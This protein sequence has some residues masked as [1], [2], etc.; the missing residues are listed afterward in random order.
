MQSKIFVPEGLTNSYIIMYHTQM[1]GRTRQ[2]ISIV[3]LLFLFLPAIS[4]TRITSPYSRFGVGELMFNQNF[5]NMG[6]GG[7]GIGYRSNH[8]VNYLNPASY[9]AVDSVSFIFEATAFSHYYQQQTVSEKQMGNYTSLGNLSFGFPVKRWW[10]VG[11]GLKPFSAV[12]YKVLNTTENAEIGTVNY[13]Y[14][15]TGGINQVFVGNAF[16]PFKGFSV[17]FN[18]SYL[19]GSMERHASVFSDSTGFFLANQI[20][21][22]QVSDWHFGFGAQYELNL[23]SNRS[24]TFGATFG[25][26]TAIN[27]RQAET[28]QR[29]LP[30]FTRFDT[31]SH[32]EGEKGSLYLPAYWGAGVFA[33]MNS[34]WAAGFDFQQQYWENYKIFDVPGDL[35][36]TYQLAFGI[37]HNPSIQTFSNFFSRLEYRAGF[38]Y[39]QTYLN[40]NDKAINEFGISFGIGLPIRRTYNGL[41][42]S[43]EF[44]QRGTTENDLIKENLYRINIGVNIHERWFM[45]RRFF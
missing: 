2:I 1:N 17:G 33:R 36:N 12:G 9:T 24:L 45:R 8:S 34:Q 30:G 44:G 37:Q 35:N 4:Q 20:K 7:I 16:K 22:N 31:I 11:V 6:M 40:L 29:M 10:G 32:Y 26:A 25:P 18:A 15:G 28:I 3:A 19:F 38:R 5:R 23:S 41:N 14:E 21:S 43:F 42:L 39:G 27:I 13:L